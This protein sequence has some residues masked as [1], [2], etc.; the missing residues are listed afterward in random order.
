[1]PLPPPITLSIWS[2]MHVTMLGEMPGSGGIS[3]VAG[4]ISSRLVTFL[5]V[6]M[7]VIVAVIV[8]LQH[9]KRSPG[10]TKCL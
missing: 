8:L 5:I 2:A 10:G 6:A 7:A 3:A 9:K 4:G 1:M